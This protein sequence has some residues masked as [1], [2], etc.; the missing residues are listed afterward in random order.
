MLS[1]D[2]RSADD[3]KERKSKS[4]V[5]REMLA[6]QALGEQLVALSPSQ[7]ARMEM[8]EDL[9]EAVLFA[10]TL[11]KGEA[12]RRQMQYIGA[13]MREADAGPIRAALEEISRGSGQ[14]AGLFRELEKWRD[15]I[16]AGDETLL[17]KA[18]DRFPGLDRR[19]LR[20][21]VLNAR[22]EKEEG[23]VPKSARALFRYL[24]GLSGA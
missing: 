22:K 24:K 20:Q 23:R 15:E 3:L 17:E 1:D 9:R 18:G 10:G 19:H 6:L 4:Q 7:V 5:K 2:S 8:P 21:L 13:L 14:D 12:L 11:K 16:I